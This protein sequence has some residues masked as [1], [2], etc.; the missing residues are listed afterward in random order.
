M[1]TL[2]INGNGTKIGDYN[3]SADKTINITP[4]NIGAAISDHTHTT[5]LATD[6]GTSN[7]TLGYGSKYKLSTGGTSTIFTMP[8]LGDTSTTA[9]AGN[10]THTLSLATTTDD[11]SITLSPAT[12]YK[13]TAGGSTYVFTT[14]SD[15]KVTSTLTSSGTTKIFLTGMAQATAATATSAE[16]HNGN[17]YVM[18][19]TGI[20]YAATPTAGTNDT[21]VATT[22]YVTTAISDAALV[23]GS[24]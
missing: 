20:L 21:S 8:S 18:P 23:W 7:I 15:T 13:L 3:G 14:P 5:T 17:V 22:A 24:F 9:A 10:H 11:S 19:N 6:N 4:S 1:K 2:T 12:K 16:Q